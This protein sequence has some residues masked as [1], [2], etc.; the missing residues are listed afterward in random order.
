MGWARPSAVEILPLAR[1]TNWHPQ[2][3]GRPAEVVLSWPIVLVDVRVAV[4]RAYGFT[5]WSVR[6]WP[7][8]TVRST[9]HSKQQRTL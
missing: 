1:F 5:D 7:R 8:E 2:L 3:V 9:R 6:P 4:A